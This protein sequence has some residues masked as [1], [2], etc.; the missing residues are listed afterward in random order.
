MEEIAKISIDE[1]ERRPDGSWVCIKNSD[2]TTKS[3]WVIRVSP[4]VIFQKNRRLFGLNVADALDK[5]SG[6]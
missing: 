6:N 1:Y 2:I 4:G 3:N 5:I